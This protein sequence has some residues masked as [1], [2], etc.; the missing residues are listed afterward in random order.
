MEVSF[1]FGFA[2]L[3]LAIAWYSVRK[4]EHSDPVDRLRQ[5]AE[6]R[7][8]GLLDDEELEMLRKRQVKRLKRWE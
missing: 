2:G 1:G 6:L 4:L 3:C 8:A 5:L 7:E